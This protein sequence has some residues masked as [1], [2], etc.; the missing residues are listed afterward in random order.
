M[1]GNSCIAT[2]SGIEPDFVTASG[3]AIKYEAANF[4]LSNDLPIPEPREAAHSRG[5]YD[6]VV[7]PLARSRQIWNAT[8][9]SSGVQ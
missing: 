5:D 2:G 6:G 4:E 8:T 9:F 7:S 3:L 1:V